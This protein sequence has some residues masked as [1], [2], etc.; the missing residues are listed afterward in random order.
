MT[1]EW[2]LT[3]FK[4][5]TRPHH[6]LCID[7]KT[8]IYWFHTS[9]GNST[10]TFIA[11]LRVILEMSFFVVWFPETLKDIH[12][13]DTWLEKNFLKWLLCF[14][15]GSLWHST[16][17][18]L[19]CF[20]SWHEHLC[21]IW[22]GIRIR[23]ERCISQ[24]RSVQFSRSVMSNSSR[25]HGLQHTRPPCPSPTPCFLFY[26][27]CGQIGN[28]QSRLLILGWVVGTP[29]SSLGREGQGIEMGTEVCYQPWPLPVGTGLCPEGGKP[30]CVSKCRSWC[31]HSSQ[32][33]YVYKDWFSFQQHEN[34][35]R[36]VWK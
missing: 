29:S 17:F 11:N 6:L 33:I 31:E 19:Y 20:Y 28:I 4:V 30:G 2:I 26:L 7:T 14:F 35:Q 22:K 3:S 24:I 10:S 25:P 1:W 34:I 21:H 13:Y 27:G 5:V 12:F 36:G 32:C 15:Q 18:Q 9:L 8:F 16:A 23:I